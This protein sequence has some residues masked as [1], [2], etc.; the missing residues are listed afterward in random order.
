MDLLDVSG[1]VFFEWFQPSIYETFLGFIGQVYEIFSS[2]F[3]P[4]QYLWDFKV[5]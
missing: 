1:R 4:R 5:Y 2:D 3:T